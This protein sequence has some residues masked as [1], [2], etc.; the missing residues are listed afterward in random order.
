MLVCLSAWKRSGKDAASD[1]L[2][3]KLGFERQSFADPLKDLVCETYGLNRDQTD[4]QGEKEQAILRLPAIASDKFSEVIHNIMSGEFKEVEGT[5]YWTPRALC[6]LE[7]S[8]KRSVNSKFWVQKALD[9]IMPGE[10]TII[11]DLR[12]KSEASQIREWAEK[13][14]EKVI[15]IRINRFESSPSQDPSER[16]MD[17]YQGFD[18]VVK[19]KGTLEEFLVEIEKIVKSELNY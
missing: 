16:D 15:F 7:G 2:I 6:I 1:H 8:I 3:R 19:N 10:D 14:G 9:K 4:N 11:S 13:K 12:Y 18:Y 5:K 17:D